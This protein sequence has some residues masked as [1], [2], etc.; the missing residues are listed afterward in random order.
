M[1]QDTR[2]LEPLPSVRTAQAAQ[3][4]DELAVPGYWPIGRG[5]ISLRTIVAP[6]W[7]WRLL[8]ILIMRVLTFLPIFFAIVPCHHAPSLM[9]A[10][11]RAVCERDTSRIGQFPMVSV[12]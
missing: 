9:F 4:Y 6:D 2:W 10:R 5:R 8:Y 1:L 7:H 3:I 12:L 11:T